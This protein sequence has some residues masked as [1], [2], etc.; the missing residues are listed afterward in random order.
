MKGKDNTLLLKGKLIKNK[1][2]DKKKYYAQRNVGGD[3]C[4]LHR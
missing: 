3:R 1:D 2:K 4:R